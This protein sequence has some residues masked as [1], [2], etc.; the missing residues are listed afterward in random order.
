VANKERNNIYAVTA[1][2]VDLALDTAGTIGSMVG[3]IANAVGIGSS[4]K[5]K[6]K[7]E[8]QQ[9]RREADSAANRVANSLREEAEAVKPPS[10]KAHASSGHAAKSRATKTAKKATKSH[11]SKST[12][13]RSAK[14]TA[15]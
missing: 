12:K 14:K 4:D 7:S 9:Q 6:K 10:H 2:A 1:D 5:D 3:T 11:S 15:H 8:E 13:S